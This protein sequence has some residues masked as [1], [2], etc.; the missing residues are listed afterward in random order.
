MKL[1]NNLN[2]QQK[3]KKIKQLEIEIKYTTLNERKNE[4]KK[5]HC[6]FRMNDNNKLRIDPKNSKIH[7]EFILRLVIQTH[8]LTK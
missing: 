4:R 5:N 7:F 6:T 3:S 2:R 1:E 8:A